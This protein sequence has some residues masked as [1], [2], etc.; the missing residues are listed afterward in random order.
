L[1]WANVIATINLS[2]VSLNLNM[3]ESLLCAICFLPLAIDRATLVPTTSNKGYLSDFIN[4]S[5]RLA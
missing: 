5:T 4:L 3:A 2:K 1:A